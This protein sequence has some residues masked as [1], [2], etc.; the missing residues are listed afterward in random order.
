[1]A[2][3]CALVALFLK[4]EW[5]V[6]G[7][8]VSAVGLA[9]QLWCFASL[10]KKKVL[11]CKGLYA[12]VRNPMYIA[13]YLLMLGVLLFTGNLWLA[14]GFT[15]IYYFYMVNRVRREELKL[16]EVFG[17][18]Y[19]AYCAEVP[20]FVP[21]FRGVDWKALPYFRWELFLVNNGHWNLLTGL[22]IYAGA[23]YLRARAYR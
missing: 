8:I 17:D 20:R 5:V 22:I 2:A 12:L 7:I 19:R 15:I 1:M 10:K 9:G 18:E 6:P 21:R 23:L 16:E 4:P 11:A 3:G 13:R 14:L